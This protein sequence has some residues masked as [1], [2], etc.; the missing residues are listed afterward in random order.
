MPQGKKKKKKKKTLA[1]RRECKLMPEHRKLGTRNLQ[2]YWGNKK[3][4]KKK[5]KLQDVIEC[6]CFNPV[7]LLLVTTNTAGN[8]GLG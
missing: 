3:I 6:R 2:Y 5:T 7:N 8:W 1:P 4:V